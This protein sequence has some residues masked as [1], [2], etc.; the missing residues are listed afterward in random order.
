MMW[1]TLFWV[2]TSP[3]WQWPINTEFG[4]TASFGEFRGT[5]F[6][7]GL[8]FSTGGVEGLPVKPA[9]P[10]V[11]F[12]VRANDSGYG[13]VIYMKHPDEKITVYAHLATFGLKL[14]K[15]IEESGVE[16]DSLFGSLELNQVVGRDDII[17]FS[18]ESG[19]GLPHFHFEVRTKQ[20]RPL[21]P[22]G[23][24]FP[25]LAIGQDR[26]VLKGFYLY[27]QGGGT[28]NDGT[29]PFWAD[30]H[31]TRVRASGTIGIRLSAYVSGPR[32][33]RL[34]CRGVRLFQD[35]RLI[36]VWQPREI[37][38]EDYRQAGLI[39]DQ[40]QSGFGPT[41]FSYCFD[42]RAAFLPELAGFTNESL[43]HV[44]KKTF[45]RV[46]LQN[47]AGSWKRYELELDPKALRRKP[48]G[49]PSLPVQAT[50]LSMEARDSRLFVW[51]ET[52]GTLE[53][54]QGLFGLAAFEKF[55]IEPKP[56]TVRSDVFWRTE[57]GAVSR[58]VGGLPL[59]RAFSYQL[60]DWML[61]ASQWPEFPAQVVFLAPPDYKIMADILDYQGP[62]LVF[63]RPGLPSK[64]LEISI[65][66]LKLK[67]PQQCAFYYWAEHKKKWQY[68]DT[69]LEENQLKANLD[70]L[71]PV[72]VARD[73]K[74]PTILS[75]KRHNYFTGTRNVIPIRD[76]G[77]GIE[78]KSIEVMGKNGVLEALYDPDRRWVVLPKGAH[79]KVWVSVRD[80]AGLESRVN[81]DL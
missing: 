54:S 41:Q 29:S 8:D 17:A 34:G 77:S 39:Y 73:L 4:L 49:L 79:G 9:K 75:A 45:L 2:V 23:Q 7:T 33:S 74:P 32:G 31:I 71:A 50:T 40:V 5:R 19:A 78:R 81:L 30:K 24:G 69:K 80:R 72:T 13:R 15:A 37:D 59:G 22:L 51:G 68:L 44:S 16:G 70:F 26:S 67:H 18:G 76:Q 62:M 57:R 55:S 65:S 21:D 10:G 48:S 38:F 56:G 27:P 58:H 20:N 64:G 11:V 43:V 3:S 1:F 36:G 25:P 42:G 14:K 28:V 52:A 66:A 53:T 12:Q 60:G 63:G 35:D 6:H 61:T 46:E 47:I